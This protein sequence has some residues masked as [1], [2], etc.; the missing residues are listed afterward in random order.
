M[1]AMPNFIRLEQKPSSTDTSGRKMHSSRSV[2]SLRNGRELRKNST[3]Q[4][5]IKDLAKRII[6]L[7]FEIQPGT[8][9]F[10]FEVIK[11][12]YIYSYINC[13]IKPLYK[14]LRVPLRTESML[15]E[16]IPTYLIIMNPEL[17]EAVIVDAKTIRDATIAMHPHM[18]KMYFEFKCPERISLVT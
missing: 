14:T 18:P 7:P 1:S 2:T 3:V 11:N 4:S 17:T 10:D 15:F 12:T 13:C 5:L 6:T 9:S 16:V 8:G